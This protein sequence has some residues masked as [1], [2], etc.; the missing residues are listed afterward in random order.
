MGFGLDYN[1]WSIFTA[2]VTSIRTR[3]S[4]TTTHAKRHQ[5]L[6]PTIRDADARNASRT[7]PR[8]PQTIAVSPPHS[9]A[10]RLLGVKH[11]VELGNGQLRCLLAHLCQ[12]RRNRPVLVLGF[13]ARLDGVP[14]LVGR[15]IVRILIQSWAAKAATENANGVEG[16]AGANLGECCLEFALLTHGVDNLVIAE[17]NTIVHDAEAEHVVDEGLAFR[18]AAGSAKDL[19][20]HFFQQKQMGLL[21]KGLVKRENRTGSLETVSRQ[22]H[23]VHR[24]NI[25]DMELGRWSMRCARDPEIQVLS[26]SHLEEHTTVAALEFA[27]FVHDVQVVLLV[28]LHIGLAMG[29]Q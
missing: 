23:L 11:C 12:L 1:I 27:H 3:H 13:E 8:D 4:H 29:H 2:R 6:V 28:E 9:I 25:F 22:F 21:V 10:N 18:V 15:D 17:P 5:I 7:H 19:D 26:L 14:V 24:V 20:E 16:E